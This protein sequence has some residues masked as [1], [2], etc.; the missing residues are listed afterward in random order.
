M[1]TPWSKSLRADGPS[2][3]DSDKTGCRFRNTAGTGK[4]WELFNTRSAPWNREPLKPEVSWGILVQAKRWWLV[5]WE[6]WWCRDSSWPK[7]WKWETERNGCVFLV[8]SGMN[9][10]CVFVWFFFRSTHLSDL[11]CDNLIFWNEQATLKQ[12]DTVDGRNPGPPEM[13]LNPVNDTT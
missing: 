8:V 11:K 9:L 1:F 6:R 13:Y 3:R 12:S 2:H 10:V 7:V 5:S 4:P